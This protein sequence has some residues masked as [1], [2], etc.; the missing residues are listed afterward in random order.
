MAVACLKSLPQRVS[1]TGDYHRSQ[2]VSPNTR[3]PN[4]NRGLLS[5]VSQISMLRSSKS[6]HQLQMLFSIEICDDNY[7]SR[8][9]VLHREQTKQRKTQ[10]RLSA[11]QT[12]LQPNASFN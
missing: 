3:K 9:G 11:R 7:E 6:L 2:D 8:R 1:T 5:A 4:C 10:G 12:K